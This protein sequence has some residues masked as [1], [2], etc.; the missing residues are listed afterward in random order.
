MQSA[1]VETRR[2]EALEGWAEGRG[3]DTETGF[4]SNMWVSLGRAIS[5]TASTTGEALGCPHPV[6]CLR[7]YRSGGVGVQRI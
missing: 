6:P 3:K 1:C 7:P 2:P 5:S 4:P